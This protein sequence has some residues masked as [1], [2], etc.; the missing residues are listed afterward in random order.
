MINRRFSREKVIQVLYSY[1]LG[2]TPDVEAVER[3]VRLGFKK[4]EGL[5]LYQLSFFVALADYFAFRFEKGKK[6]LL[7]TEEDLNPDTRFIRNRVI[8]YIRNSDVYKNSSSRKFN[9]RDNEALLKNLYDKIITSEPYQEY[10]LSEDNLAEDVD[11][12][13][14]LYKN[15]IAENHTYRDLC[16]GR[17]IF[18]ACDYNSVSYWIYE[19]IKGFGTER[20]D[21]FIEDYTEDLELSI[22]LCRETIIHRD[23]YRKIVYERFD[24]WEPERVAV[25]DRIILVTAVTEFIHCPSIPIKVTLNEFIEISKRFCSEKTHTFINGILHKVAVD[26]LEKGIIRKTGRGLI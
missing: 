7:P 8:E 14:R 12:L 18:W 25:I 1:A 26:L 3:S 22:K 16:E 23:E 4:I 17:S 20:N 10:L 24:D 21:I 6:K 19:Q 9:W 15:R 13:R 5:Y 11:Y 2:G